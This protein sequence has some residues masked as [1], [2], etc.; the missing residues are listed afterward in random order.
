MQAQALG[1]AI[2]VV[3]DAFDKEKNL[4]MRTHYKDLE[5][6]Y[7][8][9]K[10]TADEAI[11][12]TLERSKSPSNICVVTSDNDLARKAKVLKASILSLKDFL[13]FLRKRHKKESQREVDWKDSPKEISR[14]LQI[15]EEKLSKS[16]KKPSTGI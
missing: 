8:T 4:D 3:F 5:I 11:L 14:L 2:T 15:F 7:A 13:E 9:S 16:P 1:I 6:I 12:D 10:Q